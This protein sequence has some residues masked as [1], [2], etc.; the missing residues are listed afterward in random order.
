MIPPGVA[1]CRVCNFKAT[2]NQ[3][4]LHIEGW[5]LRL[6]LVRWLHLQVAGSVAEVQ[7]HEKHLQRYEHILKFQL[8]DFVGPK[9][10]FG[11]GLIKCK[12]M[13]LSSPRQCRNNALQ[14]FLASRLIWLQEGMVGQG[15]NV[16]NSKLA[17]E[18][19]DNL[20]SGSRAKEEIRACNLI[21]KG[22][23]D[24]NMLAKTL[25]LCLVNK[26]DKEKRG[27]VKQNISCGEGISKDCLTELTWR[28]GG[29]AGAH[30]LLQDLGINRASA[31]PSPHSH[32][33]IAPLNSCVV[34]VS[35]SATASHNVIRM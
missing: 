28:L 7:E 32:T 33:S 25:L 24:G 3:V 4:R 6:D 16:E 10:S 13:L 26:C 23:L 22:V 19:I 27:L 31:Q 30:A 1:C 20:S 11:R 9:S 34:Q 35:P 5:S 12:S 18:I 29:L 17:H 15:R 21:S 14:Q 8:G 2:T